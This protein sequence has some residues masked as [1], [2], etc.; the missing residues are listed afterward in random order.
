MRVDFYTKCL[1]TII[2]AC[3]IWLT[4][5][6]TVPVVHAQA[7]SNNMVHV[8]I[9]QNKAVSEVRIRGTEGVIPVGLEGTKQ[10]TTGSWNYEQ[11]IPIS[12]YTPL[13]VGLQG[14]RFEVKKQ[15]W[16]YSQPILVQEVEAKAQ[17]HP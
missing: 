15:E 8:I 3:V 14:T 6:D 5:K 11:P 16:D 2:A 10:S 7:D 13:P 4:F 12:A 17:P 9:E 1:L